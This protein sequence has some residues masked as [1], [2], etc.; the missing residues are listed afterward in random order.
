MPAH[1]QARDLDAPVAQRHTMLCLD[2]HALGR[3]RPRGHRKI[4]LLPARTQDLAG[5]HRSED[6]E[7]ERQ[8]DETVS[9][10][11]LKPAQEGRHLGVGHGRVVAGSTRLLLQRSA[12][13]I[14]GVDAVAL[15]CHACAL[16]HDADP[17]AHAPCG[18]G[19]NLPDRRQHLKHVGHRDV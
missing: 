19:L 6:G 16:Q 10:A 15:A 5:A 4:D 2:L 17:L 13:R 18:L 3:D 1:V 14:G 8:P 7:L 12:D 11:G 9:V